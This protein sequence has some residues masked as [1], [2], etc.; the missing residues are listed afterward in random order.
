[1]IDVDTATIEAKYET[2]TRFYDQVEGHWVYGPGN[3]RMD[4]GYLFFYCWWPLNGS[5]RL[6]RMRNYPC[7]MVQ[8][9]TPPVAVI[10]GL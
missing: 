5:A 3:L 2:G 10:Q 9:C 8:V 7:M 4:T 1:M 6:H